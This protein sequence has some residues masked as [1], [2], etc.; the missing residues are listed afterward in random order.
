M[1][2]RA[3]EF[4]QLART[5]FAP[6]YPVIAGQILEKSGLSQGLCLDLGCGG[7]YLG[8]AVAER[9]AFNVCLV[10]SDPAVL[11]IAHRNVKDRHLEE[12]V[13]PVLGDACRIPLESGSVHLTVSRGSMFFWEK[14]AVAFQEIYRILAPGGSAYIG[15]GF[16]T[17]HLKQKIDREMRVRNPGW[18][19]HLRQN[20]GPGA[21]RKWRRILSETGIPGFDIDHSPIG[22]WIV[23]GRHKHEM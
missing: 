19:E 17:P 18:A 6:V 3:A 23:F 5:V 15:G 10:D 9:S 16:G 21:P 20:I 4:D 22:L 2:K 11:E 12:R 1:S 13:R 8:L 14:P 7:G